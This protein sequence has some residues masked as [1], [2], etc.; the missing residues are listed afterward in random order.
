[1]GFMRSET[2]NKAVPCGMIFLGDVFV[3]SR[4]IEMGM[5]NA[6]STRNILM[7]TV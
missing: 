3:V 7:C 6:L 2:H 5:K 1:M 4:V